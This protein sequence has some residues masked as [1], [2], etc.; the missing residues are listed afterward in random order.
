M[1][2][3]NKLIISISC[4]L[5]AGCNGSLPDSGEQQGEG[6]PIDLSFNLYNAVVSKADENK[7]HGKDGCRNSLPDLCFQ[8]R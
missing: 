7:A 8:S 2:M 3:M 1:K 5:L 6:E 4:I